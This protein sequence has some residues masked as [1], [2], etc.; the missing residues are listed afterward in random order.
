M[1]NKP[2]KRKHPANEQGVLSL[3]TLLVILIRDQL[4]DT[5]KPIN[6][7]ILIAFISRLKPNVSSIVNRGNQLTLLGHSGS[8]QLE[9]FKL[10]TT[11]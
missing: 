11:F 3:S 7:S 10:Y 2:H 9:L 6:W 8:V 1:A 4:K 5:Y